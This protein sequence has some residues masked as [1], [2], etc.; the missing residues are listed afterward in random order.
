MPFRCQAEAE[1][2]LESYFDDFLQMVTESVRT[3]FEFYGEKAHLHEAW[4][5][6]SIIR[7]EI[8]ERMTEFSERVSGFQKLV[9]GNATYFGAHSKFLI[10]LKKLSDNLHAN[11][12]KT[13]LS[14]DY[15]H[16][17][18]VPVQLD[19]FEQEEPTNIYLGYIPTENAP[20]DPP[21][22]LVCNDDTGGVAWSILLNRRPPKPTITIEPP[23]AAPSGPEEPRRVRVRN[24]NTNKRSNNE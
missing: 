7:D 14:F 6:C 16:Q 9:D 10:R 22:Y 13:Q 15:D 5:R 3:Y 19:L 1:S 24:S 4:T 2:V 18:P 23:A 17:I 8:K 12:G 21:V 11:A 20:L